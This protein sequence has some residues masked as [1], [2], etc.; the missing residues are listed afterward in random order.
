MKPFIILLPSLYLLS[1]GSG[2]MKV[3][4]DNI[5]TIDASVSVENASP[6]N[7]DNSKLANNPIY[8]LDNL[9]A[10]FFAPIK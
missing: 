8:D 10:G 3:K 7:L 2:C 5:N 1:F 9:T 4:S 6:L